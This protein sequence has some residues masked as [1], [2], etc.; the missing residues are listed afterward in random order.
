MA[1]TK[2]KDL[3]DQQKSNRHKAHKSYMESHDVAEVKVLMSR[4]KRTAVQQYA[5]DHNYSSTSAF[6]N[7]AIDEKMERESD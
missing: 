4:E 3:T 7:S 6:I 2:W 5:K 1:D